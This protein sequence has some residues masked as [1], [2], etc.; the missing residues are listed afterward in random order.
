MLPRG[1]KVLHKCLGGQD[2]QISYNFFHTNRIRC[3]ISLHLHE[4]Y[5]SPVI[6]NEN[7]RGGGRYQERG[8]DCNQQI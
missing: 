3:S 8:V 1:K 4:Q 6:F 2:S 7:G 5:D